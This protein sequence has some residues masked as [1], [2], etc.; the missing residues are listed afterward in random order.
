MAGFCFKNR[1]KHDDYMTPKHAWRNIAHLIPKNKIIWEP[2]YGDGKSGKY[3]KQLGFRVIHKPVDFFKHNLGDILVSNPPFSIKKQIFTR[4]KQLEKP[5]IMICPCSMIT[6][7]YFRKL[8]SESKIQIIIPRRRIGFTKIVDGKIPDGWGGPNP[9]RANFDC[10]Y[11][12]YKMDLPSDII[13]LD[14]E[15]PKKC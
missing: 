11:Y 8:F 13:W 7:Q 6:T 2:F 12:C 10:F 4:L 5:F 15:P 1:G 14:S 3:L 9:P